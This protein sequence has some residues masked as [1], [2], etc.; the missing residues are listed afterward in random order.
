MNFETVDS[1]FKAI[2]TQ[3]RIALATARKPYRIW[4]LFTHKTS[5]FRA[6]SVMKRNCAAPISKGDVTRDDSQRR[7]LAQHSVAT[8]LRHC[9]E[10]L[11]LCSSIETMSCAK[12]RCYESSRVTSPYHLSARKAFQYSMNITQTYS[13]HV[14]SHQRKKYVWNLCSDFL[15]IF[16]HQL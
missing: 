14:R 13:L 5:A 1:L 12:N 2:F 9:L 7:R 4:H 6:I 3:Y 16:K 8:L 10:W 11:Q 15:D